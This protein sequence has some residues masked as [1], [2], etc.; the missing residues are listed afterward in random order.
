MRIFTLG[1]IASIIFQ[2]II[3]SAQKNLDLTIKIAPG[4]DKSNLSIYLNTGK[5]E[6][7]FT[8]T[9]NEIR[10]K[11]EF[12]TRY[13]HIAITIK[14]GKTDE[15]ASYGFYASDS[16]ALLKIENIENKNNFAG[17]VYSCQGLYATEKIKKQL[18]DYV[19]KEQNILDSIN[20]NSNKLD[21]HYFEA[22]KK[23][24][25]KKLSFIASHRLNYFSF[26]EFSYLSLI[27]FP[28][29]LNAHLNYLYPF[30]ED[31]FDEETKSSAEGVAVKERLIRNQ[32]VIE[33]GMTLPYFQI[34]DYKKNILNANDLSGSYTLFTFWASWCPPC[35]RELP[36]IKAIRS[37][38]P[39]SVLK[40]I[41]TNYDSDSLT[42]INHIAKYE[43]NWIHVFNT[44]VLSEKFG[45][46]G[47]GIPQIFL[48]DRQK[49]LVYSSLSGKESDAEN[50]TYLTTLLGK[51]IQNNKVG[52]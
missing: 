14:S 36:A 48:F 50:L 4:I 23:L 30:F 18:D 47:L 51:E 22:F 34:H 49:K 6:R 13:A 1:M 43:M 27:R 41:S 21:E 29:R 37:A 20:N 32:F 31:V 2:S 33:E 44:P 26:Q 45:I 52:N 39:D 3:S 35:L 12:S 19:Q 11:E 15:Q 28:G 16:S 38:Y 24:I 5:S 40:I 46:S 42:F 17:M 25:D 9:K 7:N 8:P 10:L